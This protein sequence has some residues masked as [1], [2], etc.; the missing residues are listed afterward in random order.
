MPACSPAVLDVP[1]PPSEVV[2]DPKPRI[3]PSLFVLSI[4]AGCALLFV[5]EAYLVGRYG[6]RFLP[7][8]RCAKPRRGHRLYSYRIRDDVD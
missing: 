2:A 5:S 6:E 8:T 3:R 4:I 1:A 7:V